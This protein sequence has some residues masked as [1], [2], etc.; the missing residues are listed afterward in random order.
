[1]TDKLEGLTVFLAVAETRSFRAASERL[2]VTRSAVSQ[3]FQRLEDRLG[4]ALAQ[5]TTRSVRLT[6]AGEQLYAAARPAVEDLEAALLAAQELR[7][8]PT[9]R[10]RLCVSSIADNFLKGPAL[11][12]FLAAYPNIGID[13]TVTDA[14]FDIVREGYD[15]GV[16]LGEV[17]EQDMIA[18]PVSAEQRQSTV[19]SPDYLARHGTPA[20]PRDLINHLCIGWRPNADVAPYRW[21][22]TENGRDFDVAVEPRVTTNDMNMMVRLACADVGLT[23]GMMETFQPNLQRGELVAVL[24]AFLPPFPGFFLFFPKRQHQPAKL[25]ALIDHFRAEARYIPAGRP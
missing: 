17:I 3:A 20:H 21:E 16:R 18:V 14:E 23:F 6:E 25:R 10:L 24:E 2:G 11:V 1:M 15:A 13:I 4:V 5:R 9:G 19:A 12:G 8:R 7:G 22:Y